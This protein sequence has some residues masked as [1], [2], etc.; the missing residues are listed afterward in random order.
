MP[1]RHPS[2]RVYFTVADLL[3]ALTKLV[4]E[5]PAALEVPVYAEEHDKGF[6]TWNGTIYRS[7]MSSVVLEEIKDEFAF[8]PEA[9]NVKKGCGS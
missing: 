8:D 5:D 4:A 7:G 2:G 3:V 1:G 6:I 9:I